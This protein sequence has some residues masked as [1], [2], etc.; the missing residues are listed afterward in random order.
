VALIHPP[1]LLLTAAVLAMALG[2]SSLI[3][4][5]RQA[6]IDAC[7]DSGGRWNDLICVRS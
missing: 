5:S 2:G 4:P 1:K 3:W 6:Q 7:L